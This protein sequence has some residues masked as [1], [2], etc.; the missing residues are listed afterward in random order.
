MKYRQAKIFVGM[1]KRCLM[2]KSYQKIN[3]SDFD[4]MKDTL[5]RIYMMKEDFKYL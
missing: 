2:I 4:K 5:Y 1:L 3:I